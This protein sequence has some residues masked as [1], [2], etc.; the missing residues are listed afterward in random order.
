MTR[1]YMDEKIL[2]I[3]QQTEEEWVVTKV[4]YHNYVEEITSIYDR[5]KND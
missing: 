1:E 5:L 2:K 3:R 4:E